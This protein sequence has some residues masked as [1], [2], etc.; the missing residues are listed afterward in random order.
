MNKYETYPAD[1][2]DKVGI[3][4]NTSLGIEDRRFGRANE[5]SGDNSV[6]S[7]TTNLDHY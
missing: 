5:I 4:S 6:F 3:K 1:K 2:L 7:V